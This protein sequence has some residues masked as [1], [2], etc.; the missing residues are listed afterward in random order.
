MEEEATTSKEGSQRG[1]HASGAGVEGRAVS[2]GGQL[3]EQEQEGRAAA[4]MVPG[5]EAMEVIVAAAAK[6]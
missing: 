5:V 1:P 6:G 2:A 3:G 4:A